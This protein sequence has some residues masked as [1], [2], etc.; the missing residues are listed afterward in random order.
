MTKIVSGLL[1]KLTGLWLGAFLAHMSDGQWWNF[2]VVMT[3]VVI[4]LLG[5]ATFALG[6]AEQADTQ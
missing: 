2:P 6:V 4:T 3:A 5:V 1:L